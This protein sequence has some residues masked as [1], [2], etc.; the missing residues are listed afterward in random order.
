MIPPMSYLTYKF[1]H[2][3]GIVMIFMALGAA[4]FSAR[5]TGG[6]PPSGK[7][8]LALFHGIGLL[9]VVVSGFGMLA[10]L[11]I[12]WPLPGWVH[13]KIVIWLVLGAWL[14]ICYRLAPKSTL[15]WYGALVLFM[16]AAASALFK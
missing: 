5:L 11:G 14:T 10:R 13:P 9:I 15:P 7:R 4:V 16:I 8:L 2:L 6:K 3:V 12:L 1:L